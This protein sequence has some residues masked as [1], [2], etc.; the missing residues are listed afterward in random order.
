[1][2][3]DKRINGL[4]VETGIGIASLAEKVQREE[5]LVHLDDPPKPQIA[6]RYWSIVC[7]N[8]PGPLL[9]GTWP[10]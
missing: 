6:V 5:P 4:R 2:L 8:R 10:Y 9:I 3:D 1:M 7:P